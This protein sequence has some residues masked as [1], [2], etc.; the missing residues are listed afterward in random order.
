M[1]LTSL[2]GTGFIER[3]IA[4]SLSLLRLS[5]LRDAESLLDIGCGA[6]FP[7]FPVGIV[8]DKLH[9]TMLDATRKK[10]D[11]AGQVIRELDLRNFTAVCA[12]AEDF[13]RGKRESFE[14]VTARA[15]AGLNIL[16]E[17]ALPYVKTGGVFVAMKGEKYSEEIESVRR[18]LG[19]LGCGVEQVHKYELSSS[20]GYHVVIKKYR[21]TAGL[22]PRK[23]ADIL[24]NP[25]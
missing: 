8:S 4:D 6:G 10:I 22:Y 9:V 25:L 23:Y 11:F 17:L 7:S 19:I 14:A 15:V 13:I 24:K 5:A 18:A 3:N 12:R 1:N 2:S 21:Q 16:C 20:A